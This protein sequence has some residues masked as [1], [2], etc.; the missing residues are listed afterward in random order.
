MSLVSRDLRLWITINT[1]NLN[2]HV[3][4]SI[5]PLIWFGSR[6]QLLKLHLDHQLISAPSPNFSSSSSVRDLGVTIGSALTF[7][8]HITYPF[9]LA[10]VTINWNVIA[11]RRSVS[12]K[13]FSTMVHAFVCRP[14]TH[15]LLRSPLIGLLKNR[16][17]PVHS[18]LNVSARLIA[19]LPPHSHISA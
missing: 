3:H 15:G 18:V 12:A 7:A 14:Y 8:D 10:P 6:E 13:V 4:P 9:S 2:L 1:N 17:S 5:A 11:I 19:R 16:L